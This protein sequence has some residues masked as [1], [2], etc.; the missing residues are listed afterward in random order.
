MSERRREIELLLLTIFAA[1]PLYA[2]QA[3]SFAPLI[4]FDVVMIGIVLRVLSGRDPELIPLPVMR[5]LAIAYIL[6]YAVDAAVI[7]RSA[8]SASTHLVLFIA[9]YQPMEPANR[10][11]EAQ[12]LLTASLIFVA[13]VATATHIAI[14]PFVIPVSFPLFPQLNHLSHRDSVEAAG[15]AAVF[16]PPPRAPAVCGLGPPVSGD[17]LWSRPSPPRDPPAPRT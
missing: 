2:T 7:S 13:S 9:A 11:N 14:V 3:I 17:P 15:V 12:R 8:I 16:P 4:A 10:R 5:G 1:V 6:F